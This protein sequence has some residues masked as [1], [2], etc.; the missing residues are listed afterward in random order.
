MQKRWISSKE[1]CGS[2]EGNKRKLGDDIVE[3]GAFLHEGDG[4]V[5]GGG[6]V[7]GERKWLGAP[8][9]SAGHDH[10]ATREGS[11]LE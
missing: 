5:V 8:P 6:E 11:S 7:C 1:P 10:T 2:V 3:I 4:W 9:L